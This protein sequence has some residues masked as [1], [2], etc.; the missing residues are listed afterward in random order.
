MNSHM[1]RQAAQLRE[2]WLH[3]VHLQGF[4]RYKFAYAY[5]LIHWSLR[6]DLWTTNHVLQLD[7]RVQCELSYVPL[8]SKLG[9]FWTAV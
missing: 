8:G 4:H 3:N 7:Y 1:H 6:Y 9:A 2:A 5:I